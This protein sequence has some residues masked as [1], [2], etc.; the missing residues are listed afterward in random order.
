LGWT[1]LEPVESIFSTWLVV[2]RPK[3]VRNAILRRRGTGS[4][5]KPE[6]QQKAH[7]L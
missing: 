6:Q 4:R 7:R 3:G 2:K 5:L 1:A